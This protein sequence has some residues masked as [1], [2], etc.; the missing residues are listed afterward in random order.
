MLAQ[1][2]IEHE[3]YDLAYEEIKKATALSPRN[4]DRNKKSWDLARLNHDHLGQYQA[5][6]NIAKNAKN[7][8]HDSPGLLLNVIRA[9][10][11]LAC[12]ITDGSAETL[13]KQTDGYFA[14]LEREYKDTELFKEQIIVAR[15][16]LLNARSQPEKA[17]RLVENQV[18][19]RPSEFIED[20]LDKVKVYHELGMREE[21][22]L[23][24]EAIKN[25]ISGDSLASQVV[26]RY[27]EIETK[28]RTDI[29]FT[30]KQLHDMAVEHY[31]KK[32]YVP[33]LEAVLQAF[34]LA[35]HSIKFAI[36]LLKIM[37]TIKQADK[38]DDQYLEQA[39]IRANSKI[40]I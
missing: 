18:S 40:Y 19:I 33:A 37:T 5:T 11:D 26:N 22:V 24:L 16:R 30:P 36:S 31:Q 1:Y 38:L 28:E 8:I 29:H 27:I 35:P 21:A 12:T 25:Q 9:S 20:N 10:I 13:L 17:E 14:Q 34:Q 23:L 39:L 7:S 4:I 6:K 3:M 15:A 32:R 2:H